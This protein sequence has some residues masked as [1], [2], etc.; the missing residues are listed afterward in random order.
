MP[1]PIDTLE[2]VTAARVREWLAT[3][4]EAGVELRVTEGRR[5]WERQAALYA[6]G[7]TLPGAIVTHA[8]P[9][10]D[11]HVRGAAADFCFRGPVPYPPLA[12]ARWQLVGELATKAALAWG[13]GWKHPDWDHVERPDWSSLPV[14]PRE[15]A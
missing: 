7:R 5:S 8:R 13:G 11:P 14:A 9:E 1:D 2:P 4:L 15:L 10:A 12:D 6:R 3:C